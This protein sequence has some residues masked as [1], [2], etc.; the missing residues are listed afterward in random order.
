MDV[1]IKNLAVTMKLGNNGVELDVYDSDGKH[2]GDLR[3]GRAKVAWFKG[4]TQVGNGIKVSWD[5]LIDWFES[6][7]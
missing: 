4:K 7:H 5:K 1:S 2:L 6:S 3:I